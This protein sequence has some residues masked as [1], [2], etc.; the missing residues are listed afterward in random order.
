MNRGTT[1]RITDSLKLSNFTVFDEV[2]PHPSIEDLRQAQS[3]LQDLDIEQIVAIGGGSVLDFAKL[4]ALVLHPE[5]RQLEAWD[6]CTSDVGNARCLPVIALPTTTGTGSEVTP[7]ATIW[8]KE[9]LKKYS[10][11]NINLAPSISMIC[12]EPLNTMHSD[13]LLVSVYDSLSHC[14]ETLWNRNS[15]P[16]TRSFAREGIRCVASGFLKMLVREDT[17]FALEDFQVGSLLGGLAISNNYTALAHAIS[18]HLTL[19]FGIPHGLAS[20]FLLPEISEFV[21]SSASLEPNNLEALK[22]ASQIITDQKVKDRVRQQLPLFDIDDLVQDVWSANRLAN[23]LIELR[24]DELTTF[25]AT[26]I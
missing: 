20:S 21:L 2:T 23:F 18:Y 26:A 12:P 1:A 3:K 13:L 4:L 16:L 15:T 17:S 19:N 9:K 7:F 10:I 8:D 25:L 22:I 14:A 6:T 5:N 11:E 24:Q